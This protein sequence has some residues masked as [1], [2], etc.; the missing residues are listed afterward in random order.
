MIA[1]ANLSGR[2]GFVPLANLSERQQM[3]VFYT[4][5]GQG[6][7]LPDCG[8]LD[9]TMVGSVLVEREMRARC[10]VVAEIGGENSPQMAFSEHRRFEL[11]T[12]GF[13]EG[14]GRSPKSIGAVVRT[15][16]K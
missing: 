9:W 4:D 3:K 1:A 6:D 2:Q 16:V 8:R 14:C 12:L 10:M 11:G 15:V 7:D 13:A 5:V